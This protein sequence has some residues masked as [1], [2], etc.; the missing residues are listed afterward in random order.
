MAASKPLGVRILEQRKITHQVFEFDDS[1]RSA[2]EVARLTGVEPDRVLKTLVVEHDPPKGKPMLVMMPSMVEID[3]RKLAAVV[4][5]LP[6]ED[7]SATDSGRALL[8]LFAIAAATLILLG[9]FVAL[10]RS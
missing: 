9:V 4:G 10:S 7:S 2:Q 1:V 5:D 3:L 8:L 6:S